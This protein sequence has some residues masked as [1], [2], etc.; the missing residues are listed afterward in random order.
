MYVSYRK[1]ELLRALFCAVAFSCSDK[2]PRE[3]K[4]LLYVVGPLLPSPKS[5]HARAPNLVPSRPDHLGWLDLSISCPINLLYELLYAVQ[6]IPRPLMAGNVLDPTFLF[7]NIKSCL[8]IVPVLSLFE[9]FFFNVDSGRD[10]LFTTDM[11]SMRTWACP[12]NGIPI[13]RNL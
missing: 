7:L 2:K 6:D 13:I 9:F 12:S 1:R 8:L 5:T 3:K 10:V 11:L 4:P